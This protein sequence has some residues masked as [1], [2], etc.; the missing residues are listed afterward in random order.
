M[1]MEHPQILNR[2]TTITTTLSAKKRFNLARSTLN[3]MVQVFD[4]VQQIVR[5]PKIHICWIT[6]T[7]HLHLMNVLGKL[8]KVENLKN[9]SIKE[10]I[11]IKPINEFPYNFIYLSF[12]L[13]QRRKSVVLQTSIFITSSMTDQIR[14]AQLLP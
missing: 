1:F 3:F 7:Q 2:T 13:F 14:T 12:V 8:G 9:Y 10:I 5:N 11:V 6:T 4:K